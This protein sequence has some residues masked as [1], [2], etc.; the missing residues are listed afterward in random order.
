MKFKTCKETFTDDCKLHSQSGSVRVFYKRAGAV[1]LTVTHTGISDSVI[2]I[3]PKNEDGDWTVSLIAS[4]DNDVNQYYDYGIDEPDRKAALELVTGL[5]IDNDG[6][7]QET[8]DVFMEDI[9]NIVKIRKSEE[10][11]S[12][13]FNDIKF[14]KNV[15]FPFDLGPQTGLAD[16]DRIGDHVKIKWN[17]EYKVYV[18]GPYGKNESRKHWSA[19]TDGMSI[20]VFVDVSPRELWKTLDRDYS[21]GY[22]TMILE[23]DK[24]AGVS[25]MRILEELNIQ[26]K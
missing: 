20:T 5:L 18:M 17:S 26:W 3:I 12:P 11:K 14:P 23:R 1:G 7:F 24:H 22:R 16:S 19:V 15:R 6:D 2:S 10:K 25:L 21:Q 4:D 8:F 9:V 13:S